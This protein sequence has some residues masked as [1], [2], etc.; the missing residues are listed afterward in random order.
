[1]DWQYHCM[2]WFFLFSLLWLIAWEWRGPEHHQPDYSSHHYYTS[3]IHFLSWP[4][5]PSV[6]K[7]SLA[8][9]IATGTH[10]T[11]VQFGILATSVSAVVKIQIRCSQLC[12]NCTI[13]HFKMVISLGFRLLSWLCLQVMERLSTVVK[14]RMRM[15]LM[16][17]GV[18]WEHWGSSWMWRGNVKVPTSYLLLEKQDS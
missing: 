1:M 5:M 9:A 6:S 15:S 17:Q 4:R 2:L 7:V 18:I 12:G 3:K 13:N 14:Q 10:G 8:G 11:G 16:P